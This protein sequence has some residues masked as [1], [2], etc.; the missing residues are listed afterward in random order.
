M[1]HPSYDYDVA[2]I[3]GGPA[4]SSAATTLAR[5]GR[6]VVLFEKDRFPRFHIGESLLATSNESFEKLGLRDKVAAAGFTRKWGASFGPADGSAESYADFTVSPEIPYPQTWQVP[7]ERLDELLLGHAANCGAEVRQEHRVLD[8]AFDAAG[9]TLE[10]AGPA[11]ARRTVRVQAVIDA[12]GRLGILARKFRLRVEEPRLANIAIY[13]HFSGVPRPEGRRAGDIRIVGRDD[14]GWFWFIPI[15]ETLMS[16]G[17]VL[18]R[19]VFDTWP[20]LSHEEILERAIADTPAAAALMRTARREWPVRVEK[21]FSYHVRAYAGDRWLLAGDAGSFL[22]PVF[23]TGVTIALESG[24]EAGRALDAALA[25]GDLSASSFANFQRVQRRRYRMFRR[26]VVGFYTPN[27]RDLFF[28][29]GDGRHLFAAV[30]TTVAGRWW[31]S[32]PRRLLVR[33]FFFLVWLQ[34]WV[35][36]ARRMAHHAGAAAPPAMPAAAPPRTNP[37]SPA[38]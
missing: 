14:M 24:I 21:D 27:F 25:K 4:G 8:V 1:S 32:F 7:R 19:R 3:G 30:V 5:Q 22:D 28:Q 17:V 16:V 15:S 26:F 34:R 12:S 20:R 33:F 18:Q 13:A 36:V 35:P 9:V 29:P 37:R 6:R 11:E 23:S 10:V 2:I 38:G 31:P